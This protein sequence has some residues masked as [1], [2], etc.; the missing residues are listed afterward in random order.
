[1]KTVGKTASK[2]RQTF[3]SHFMDFLNKTAIKSELHEE[4][5]EINLKEG[6]SQNNRNRQL[7]YWMVG[8]RLGKIGSVEFTPLPSS[9][10][11]KKDKEV[12]LPEADA[13]APFS[14][15]QPYRKWIIEVSVC[16]HIPQ[17]FQ[18]AVEHFLCTWGKR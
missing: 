11:L 4:S 2:D 13:K 3:L 1:M 15:S 10:L 18:F 9:L 8:V 12:N 7:K 16:E 6:K 17:T 14:G 5:I